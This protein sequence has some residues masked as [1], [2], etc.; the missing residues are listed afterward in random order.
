MNSSEKIDKKEIEEFVW[1]LSMEVLMPGIQSVD[2]YRDILARLTFYKRVSDRFDER[3]EEIMRRDGI[4]KEAAKKKK[5]QYRFYVPDEAHWSALE[6]RLND[7]I[8]PAIQKAFKLIE[9]ANDNIPEGM[10]TMSSFCEKYEWVLDELMGEFSKKQFANKN[11]KN[12]DTLGHLVERLTYW[13]DNKKVNNGRDYYESQKVNR[14]LAHL[15]A[16]KPGMTV[17]DPC[18]GFGN[19]L[20]ELSRHVNN[21]IEIYGQENNLGRWSVG[22]INMMLHRIHDAD[23]ACGDAL[24]SPQFI[25][26][27]KPKKFDRIVASPPKYKRWQKDQIENDQIDNQFPYGLPSTAHTDWFWVQHV[28]SSMKDGGKAG[29]I[30]GSGALFRGGKEKE[31]RKAILQDDLIE[32]VIALPQRLAPDPVSNNILI[33]K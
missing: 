24:A 26:G 7:D 13:P 8:G 9:E 10:L 27:E 1:Y 25:E 30:L 20:I 32:A 22:E 14:L 5:D 6:K 4:S 16:P 23:L 21:E 15:L 19:T 17:Y 3:T 28:I 33:L 29:V 2:E 31:I 18:F 12:S 11:L